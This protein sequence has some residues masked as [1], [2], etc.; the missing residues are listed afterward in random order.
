M[1][2]DSFV[3]FVHRYFLELS[4][5]KDR[6]RACTGLV[7]KKEADKQLKRRKIWHDCTLD[8]QTN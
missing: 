6:A 2:Q 3:Q 8:T 1:F 4:I 5:C 7:R